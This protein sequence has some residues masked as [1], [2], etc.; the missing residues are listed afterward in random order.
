MPTRESAIAL[1]VVLL[2][3]P[4]G[5]AEQDASA[6]C[7]TCHPDES[8]RLA[9]S[10]HR[11]I[12]CNECHRGQESYPLAPQEA[13]KFQR[14]TPDTGLTFDHGSSFAG[15]P[16]RTDVPLLCGECHA[17][18][19]RMNPYGLRTDQLAQYKT[20]MHGKALFGQQDDRVAICTDCHGPPHAVLHAGDPQ[21]HTH[22]LN[23]PAMCASCH[24]NA[25][26]MGQYKLPTEV[27]SEYR[28]SVHGTLLLER[29]DTGAPTCATCHGNHSAAPP[30]FASVGAVCGRCH[31]HDAKYFAAS[32]HADQ[33][34][35][36]GCVQCHGG[37]AGRHF[38][39]IERITQPTGVMIQRYA[40]LLAAGPEPTPRQIAEA[41]QPDARKIITQALPACTQCHDDIEKDERI[42]KLFKLLDEIA[43]AQRDYVKT[44]ARLDEI[45]RGVL[46]VDNQRFKF[47]DARTHLIAL[48]P[49]QHALDL[50]MI[51]EKVA[52]LAA[53]CSAVNVELDDLEGGLR[54]RRGLLVVIWLVAVAFAVLCYAQYKKLRAR[55]V[56]TPEGP[57]PAA[58][59][60]PTRRGFL[61]WAVGVATA[62]AGAVLAVPALL[63]LWPAARGG[64]HVV[65]KVENAAQLQPGDATMVQLAGKAVI[66]VRGR[67]GYRAFSAVCTHLGCLV[68]WDAAAK[69]FKCPCHAAVFDENGR[70]VSGPPPA[71]LPEYVVK[72]IDGQVLVSPA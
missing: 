20:S 32:V 16:K 23:V 52:E 41:T 66:V 9:A 40:H 39:L 67:S 43:G 57:P 48:A 37:G 13:E 59:A 27:V 56:A 8:N 53:E 2:G 46:L 14:R 35:H 42:P 60:G 51:R 4:A 54:L 38:H 26:L 3:L 68:K 31:E 24:E 71:P 28:Q 44:A 62:G 64:K 63:Y 65:A 21:S 12:H 19:E 1:V 50:P 55:L 33:A 10:V 11:T 69:E 34:G 6:T 25:A 29:K 5:A 36:K 17:D 30:G 70:V 72:E 22:P 7:A 61:D 45:G 47:E 49:M 58:T 15:R 18:V